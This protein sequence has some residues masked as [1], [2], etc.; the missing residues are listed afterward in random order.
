[1]A[2]SVV[3]FTFDRN[4]PRQSGK[5][6]R[7]MLPQ[8]LLEACE[9]RRELAEHRKLHHLLHGWLL[10]HVPLSFALLVLTVIHVVTAVYW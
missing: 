5:E 4:A 7:A 9:E 6:L 8:P 2:R 10:L 1:M 3:P